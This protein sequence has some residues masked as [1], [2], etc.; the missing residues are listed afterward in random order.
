MSAEKF[1]QLQRDVKHNQEDLQDF[2]RDLNAWETN[3]KKKD[4]ELKHGDTSPGEKILP[5][6]RNRKS[7]AKKKRKKKKDAAIKGPPIAPDAVPNSSSNAQTKKI[8]AYD[9]RDWDKFDVDA[10]CAAVDSD[11]DESNRKVKGVE[12]E[13]EETDSEAEREEMEEQRKI[14]E[15]NAE[16]EKG[17]TLFKKGKYEEALS[18][19]SKGLDVDPNNAL[20]TANRA[21]ALLKLKRYE[22]AEGDCDTAIALDCTYV[23]AYARRGTARLE[24]GKLEEAKK[25]FEQVLNIETE[26]K[27][28]KNEIKKIERLLKEREEERRRAEEPSNIV[29]AIDKPLHLRSTRPLKRMTVQEVGKGV[30]EEKQRERERLKMQKEEADSKSRPADNKKG[31]SIEESSGLPGKIQEVKSRTEENPS[32][33]AQNNEQ[34]ESPR[35]KT[36]SSIKGKPPMMSSTKPAVPNIPPSSFQLQA[37][38]KRLKGHPDVLFEYFKKIPPTRYPKLFQNSLDS[39]MLTQILSLLTES[40]VP[41]KTPIF[42]V[43]ERLSAVKRF[44]MNVMFMSAKEKQVVRDLFSHL[45][46]EEVDEQS[47]LQ[48]KKKYGL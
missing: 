24:L 7:D 36:C 42:S 2:L 28:A 33:Q 39:T 9:Y 46:S 45:N 15:A 41:S 16:K 12:E 38:W 20:L 48:L 11:D 18:C 26:N 8:R 44:D 4:Q 37:D 47:C 32:G 13:E 31:S 34:S 40:Y 30:A 43:L 35:E 19:Y 22:E 25:D 14:M 3:V 23:K 29:H 1:V 6:V 5:P 27:Q 21:M 10:A 17:N